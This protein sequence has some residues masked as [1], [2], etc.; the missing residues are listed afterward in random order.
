MG[1]IRNVFKSNWKKIRSLGYALTCK[2]VAKTI[3]RGPSRTCQIPTLQKLMSET[4]GLSDNGH[5]V[6]VGAFDGERFSNTSWLADNGWK[7]IYV[8]P[9]A[10]YSKL[11]RLRHC[12]NKVRVL[13][14]A[15][16]EA[17]A[18]ATLRQMGALSTISDDTF[19]EY[20]KIPWANSQIQKSCE[21]HI[22]K[23][24]T[25]DSLLQSGNCQPGFELLVV[26]V[27][28]FEESVFKGFSIERWQPRMMIVELCDVHPDFAANRSLTE[29]AAR[30]RQAIL[31][32]GYVEVFCDQINTVFCRPF[33]ES[34]EVEPKMRR[35]A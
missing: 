23:I 5:F 34:S 35:A 21:E 18:E 6:E 1:I 19:R 14:V 16:G 33:R 17:N 9:S 4:I 15:A 25:L 20:E 7:G 31:K 30:V 13:N 2:A 24:Q 29:S 3:G 32:S 27:E 8:E 28:G 26:D 12:L 11:C 22:T 10:E